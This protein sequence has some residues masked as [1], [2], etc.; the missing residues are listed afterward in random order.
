M[1]LSARIEPGPQVLELL[2]AESG[3]DVGGEQGASSGV[4]TRRQHDVV[5]GHAFAP[6]ALGQVMGHA[7]D[8]VGIAAPQVDLA[9]AIKVNGQLADGAGHEL[10]QANGASKRAQH[11]Q[12]IGLLFGAQAQEL[13]KL[14]PEKSAAVAAAFGEVQAQGGQHI[15]HAETARVAAIGGLNADDARNDFHGHAI[16]GFSALQQGF[17][18]APELH[19]GLQTDGFDEACSVSGPVLGARVGGRHD[20]PCDAFTVLRLSQDRHRPG[21]IDLVFERQLLSQLLCLWMQGIAAR[22]W[23]DRQWQALRRQPGQRGGGSS[24]CGLGGGR[25]CR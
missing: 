20:Q 17:V 14:I 13:A 12:G 5:G 7:A 23:V 16:R 21:G 2:G 25:A 6:T 10:R 8:G 11:A 19:A 1:F 3:F 15:Q 9:I 4:V 22:T 18:L 24:M